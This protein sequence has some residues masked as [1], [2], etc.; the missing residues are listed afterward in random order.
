ME[1]FHLA[2]LHITGE[3][4]SWWGANSKQVP[5]RFSHSRIAAISSGTASCSER[6]WSSPNAISVSASA[7]M[8]LS[9]G[10]VNPAWSIRWNTAT[11]WPVASP[12]IRWK[13]SVER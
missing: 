8:R 10:C 7:S 2:L 9:I 3:A 6:I 5:S 11:G 12:A 13:L 1:V 4:E